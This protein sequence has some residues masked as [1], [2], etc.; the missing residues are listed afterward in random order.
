MERNRY[1]T[2]VPGDPRWTKYHDCLADADAEVQRARTDD[3][4]VLLITRDETVP[5]DDA[6]CALMPKSLPD[7]LPVD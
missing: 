5:G 2:Y 1:R 4:R 3:A 7:R 6:Q